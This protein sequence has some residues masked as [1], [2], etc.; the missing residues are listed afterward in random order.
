MCNMQTCTRTQKSQEAEELKPK[1]IL[2]DLF[3]L[4]AQNTVFGVGINQMCILSLWLW[5]TTV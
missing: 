5:F 2:L 1:L 3:G 4:F